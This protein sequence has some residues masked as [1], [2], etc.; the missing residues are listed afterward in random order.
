VQAVA[1]E[2]VQQSMMQAA[3][4][5]FVLLAAAANMQGSPARIMQ[6]AL[7]SSRSVPAAACSQGV[8]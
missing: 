2:C 6:Q 8:L 1:V 5:T 4:L 7:I 3:Q